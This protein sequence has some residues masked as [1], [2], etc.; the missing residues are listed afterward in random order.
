MVLESLPTV[1]FEA[2]LPLIRVTKQI[3]LSRLRTLMP[4]G[5][6]EA[7]KEVSVTSHQKEAGKLAEDFM[8]CPWYIKV[9]SGEI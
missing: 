4:A 6:P 8:L 3:S 5:A 9:P 7:A 1:S 2:L